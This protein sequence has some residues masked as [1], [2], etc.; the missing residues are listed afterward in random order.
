MFTV[1]SA[2]P[3]VDEV[4]AAQ[5]HTLDATSPAG[6]ADAGAHGHRRARRA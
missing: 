2:V 1:S 4:P 6:T 5:Y 3:S